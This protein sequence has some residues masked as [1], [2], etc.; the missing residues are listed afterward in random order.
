LVTFAAI[1]LVLLGIY[2][3]ALSIT[4]FFRDAFGALPPLAGNDNLVWGGVD[5]LGAVVFLYAGYALLQGWAAGRL[6]ALLVAV[7]TAFRWA[8]Y[9]QLIPVAAVVVVVICALIIYTLAVS[10]EYFSHR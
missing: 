4:E 7:L 6:I 3:L 2:E 10:D 8:T 5:V 1:L 9:V